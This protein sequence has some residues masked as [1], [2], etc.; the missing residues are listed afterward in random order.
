MQYFKEESCRSP[1]HSTLVL[2]RCHVT[3][4][5]RGTFELRSS[6]DKVS[7]LLIDSIDSLEYETRVG[8]SVA[9]RVQIHALLTCISHRLCMCNSTG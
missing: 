4:T 3:S 9:I 8:P 2:D 5:Q 7:G 6:Y 1:K